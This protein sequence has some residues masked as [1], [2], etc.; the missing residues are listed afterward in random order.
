MFTNRKIASVSLIIG[1]VSLL[2]AS[3][4]M[5]P[6]STSASTLLSLNKPA[7]ASS[8]QQNSA[9]YAPGHVTDGTALAGAADDEAEPRGGRVGIRIDPKALERWKVPSEN[10]LYAD[11]DGNVYSFNTST[12]KLNW[13]PVKPDGPI[14]ASPLVREDYILI[15]TE[16]GSIY[17]LGRD[18]RVLWQQEVGGKIYT[19][20]IAAGD[21][22]LIA[23][24]ETEFYLAGLDLNGRQ[25]WAF[26]PE[27]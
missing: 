6:V 10:L 5:M 25:V 27:N 15:A 9:T 7:T 19:T 3:L 8:I 24:L 11:V 14:T 12:G 2:L 13:N 18:G 26:T 4:L 21:L 20:P 23:P 16:S 22:T 17:A 1:A